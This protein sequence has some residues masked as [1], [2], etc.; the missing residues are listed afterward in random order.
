MANAANDGR[1]L[2]RPIN[3]L[4]WVTKDLWIV[5]DQ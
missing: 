5:E 1:M 4:K 3:T 2:Y